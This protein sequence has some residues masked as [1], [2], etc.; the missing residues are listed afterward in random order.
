[1]GTFDEEEDDVSS[2]QIRVCSSVAMEPIWTSV[3][4]VAGTLLG[5][6]VTYPF[7]RLAAKR[8]TLRD[9]R[10]AAYTAFAAARRPPA[11]R[12]RGQGMVTSQVPAHFTSTKS[13]RPDLASVRDVPAKW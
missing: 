2:T 10:I 9:E 5:A 7:Q 8:Q 1:M 12:C 13:A 11:R 3:V 4:A 6:F